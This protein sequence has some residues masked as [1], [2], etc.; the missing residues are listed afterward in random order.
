[1]E[2]CVCM[3]KK[4]IAFLKKCKHYDVCR[5]CLLAHKG[6]CPMCRTP[7]IDDD[8]VDL[9]KHLGNNVSG[10]MECCVCL[11]KKNIVF[12]K[13]CKH[14]DVCRECLLAKGACPICKTSY[15]DDDIVD[16]RKH[17]DDTED[18]D[19]PDRRFTYWHVYCEV[20]KRKGFLV[21]PDAD[22]RIERFVEFIQIKISIGDVSRNPVVIQTQYVDQTWRAFL[23]AP[24]I[25]HEFCSAIGTGCVI[26]YSPHTVVDELSDTLY[27]L[28]FEKFITGN[29]CD[30]RK[31]TIG[32]KTVRV[33]M[34][35]TI[36][37]LRKIVKCD[38]LLCNGTM[39]DDNKRLCD[40]ARIG[41]FTTK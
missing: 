23:M 16:L 6:G 28:F 26:D 4:D 3:A 35:L 13:K 38:K 7:Y 40:Y 5:E 1:M 18:A 11:E 33:P 36:G 21:L 24:V 17:L 19:H 15:S 8:I 31:I 37:D 2:C 10:L 30:V 25:Y 39:L 20:D 29:D 9:R 14:Y 22:K 41:A 34:A 32:A 12:L 27:R